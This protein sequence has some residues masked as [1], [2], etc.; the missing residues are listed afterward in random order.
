MGH[1]NNNKKFFLIIIFF[2]VFYVAHAI[3]FMLLLL[4]HYLSGNDTHFLTL[5]Y[6]HI[7]RHT[8]TN[9]TLNELMII[10]KKEII[11]TCTSIKIPDKT[12]N[13]T[14]TYFCETDV[15]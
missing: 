8:H 12:P 10:E 5:I 4:P 11:L 13:Q 3:F 2:N 7:S 14:L 6:K 15:H 1:F 9:R